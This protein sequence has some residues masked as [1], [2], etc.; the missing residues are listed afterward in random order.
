MIST[1]TTA[2]RTRPPPP[3]GIAHLRGEGKHA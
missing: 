3:G 2:K 1:D